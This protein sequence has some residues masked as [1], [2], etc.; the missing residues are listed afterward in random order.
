MASSQNTIPTEQVIAFLRRAQKICI[1]L[2]EKFSGDDIC[3]LLALKKMLESSGKDVTAVAPGPFPS[4]LEFVGGKASLAQGLG[5]DSD[6]IISVSTDQAKVDRVKYSVKEN[7]VDILI[8]PKSGFFSERDVTFS[9]SEGGFDLIVVLGAE[10]LESLGK[11]FEEHTQLFATVPIVNISVS[12]SNDFFGRVNLTDVSRSAVCEVLFDLFQSTEPFSGFIDEDIATLL[13]AGII[14]RTG[15]FQEPGTTASAFEAASGLQARGAAQSDIIEHLFKMKSLPTLKI[16]GRV[17]GNLEFDPVHK[18]IWSG[19]GK[20][21]FELAEAEST[22]IED[23]TGELLRHM[24]GAELAVLFIEEKSGARVSLRSSAPN[25]NFSE[26]NRALG[27]A[28]EMVTHGLDFF[29]EKRTLAEIQFQLLQLVI[30]FQKRRLHIPEDVEIQKEELLQADPAQTS[31]LP[32]KTE[33]PTI[34][35]TPPANIPFDAPFQSHE[36]TGAMPKS[37]DVPPGTS[38]AEVTLDPSD[39]RIPDWLKKSFPKNDNL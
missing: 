22:D 31:F 33:G 38:A 6:F 35:P 12:P 36:S 30:D 17:L 18:V 29:L 11:T 7:S 37:S 16:W 25:I 9:Q 2:P 4:N 5:E 10:K 27:G 34:S 3:G 23:M 39:S 26:L 1:T 20:A 32:Q 15:S 19:I 24:K 8:S 13:L 14:E 21:D 28:G